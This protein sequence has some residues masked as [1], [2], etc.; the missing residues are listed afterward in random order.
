[1]AR[2]TIIFIDP[3]SSAV[4]CQE[5]D[6][7]VRRF[8]A[9]KMWEVHFQGRLKTDSRRGRKGNLTTVLKSKSSAVA[10]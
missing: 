9:L 3:L 7:A 5:I 10:R 2:N 8:W 6:M 4:G 1:M